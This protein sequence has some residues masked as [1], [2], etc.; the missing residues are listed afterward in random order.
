MEPCAAPEISEIDAEAGP[1]RMRE[2]LGRRG[3]GNRPVA[4]SLEAVQ[5]DMTPAQ[6]RVLRRLVQEEFG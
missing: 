6:R 1:V 3:F 5:D 4:T 2:R